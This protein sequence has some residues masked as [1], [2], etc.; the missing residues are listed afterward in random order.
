M[1]EN[2]YKII[3]IRFK[4]PYEDKILFGQPAIDRLNSEKSYYQ[5]ISKA[6]FEMMSRMDLGD[7]WGKYA[8]HS[9]IL[10]ELPKDCS[11][12]IRMPKCIS[13]NVNLSY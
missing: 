1:T 12:D 7:K 2:F 10:F 13:I 4:T 3:A 9:P 11:F 6:E 5:L 8:D